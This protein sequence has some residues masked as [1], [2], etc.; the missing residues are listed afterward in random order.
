MRVVEAEAPASPKSPVGSEDTTAGFV[1]AFSAYTLWGFLPLYMKLLD[2]IPAVEVIAYRAF[3]SLPVASLILWWLGRTGDILPTLKSPRRLAILFATAFVI[4][5]NWGIYVWAI[6]VERTIETA[7]GYYIN[8]LITVALAAIFLGDRFTRP[9]LLA[10]SLAVLA[11]LILT[12]RG[13]GLPWVSLVLAFSFA[14]YGFLRKMVDVGPTQGFLVE[15]LLLAPIAFG[16]IL[17]W[18]M[19]GTSHFLDAPWLTLMFLGCGP[20]TAVP[21]ILYA[22]GAK[23]LRLSTI[24]LMQYIAP[25]MIF[26]IGLFVF[27]EPFSTWQLIAFIMIWAALAIYSWSVFIRPRA[28]PV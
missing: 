10:I 16:F 14:T 21:L 17:Y 23:G 2:K 26:L 6:S 22:F 25:T 5:L 27:G 11:V 8:P 19:T 12:V 7:M 1:Y 28:K 9:Q 15:V 4:S 3:W 20:V 18:Q 13:G 24:G